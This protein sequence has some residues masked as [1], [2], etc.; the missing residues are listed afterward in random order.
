M[1]KRRASG[2]ASNKGRVARVLGHGGEGAWRNLSL[3]VG[4]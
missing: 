1:G 2:F 3:T 4:T